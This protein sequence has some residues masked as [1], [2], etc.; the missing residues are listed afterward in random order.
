MV[1]IRFAK[2]Y[3][4]VAGVTQRRSRHVL[5]PRSKLYAYSR[6][7]PAIGADLSQCTLN[8]HHAVFTTTPLTA[9][10]L[11]NLAESREI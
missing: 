4:Y 10:R 2:H 1:T 5:L 3:V 11:T 6:E 9:Y 7:L 8:P